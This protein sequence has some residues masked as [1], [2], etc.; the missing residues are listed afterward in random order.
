MAAQ[1]TIIPI[2]EQ[3]PLKQGLKHF[4]GANS[5]ILPMLKSSLRQLKFILFWPVI[6]LSAIRTMKIGSNT[7]LK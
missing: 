4:E 6:V 5:F 3:G 2:R 7:Y 1:F